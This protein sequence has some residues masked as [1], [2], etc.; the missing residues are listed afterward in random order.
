MD[1]MIIF[2]LVNCGL[3]GFNTSVILEDRSTFVRLLTSF[4]LSMIFAFLWIA[5]KNN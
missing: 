3:I 4:T 1:Y 5:I 2:Y